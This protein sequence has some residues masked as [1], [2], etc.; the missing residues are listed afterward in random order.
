MQLLQLLNK[1]GILIASH[2]KKHCFSALASDKSG[3]YL[4]CGYSNGSIL[5]VNTS[6]IH[7]KN[8]GTQLIGVNL[9][10]KNLTFTD[11]N[12]L[13]AHAKPELFVPNKHSGY[14]SLWDT[15]GN[16]IINFG[17]SVLDA[18]ISKNGRIIT[19]IES[20][21]QSRS[22]AKNLEL[23]CYDISQPLPAPT[24]KQAYNLL[25]ESKK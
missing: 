12:L 23:I 2:T 10:I 25:Q 17:S 6:D 22:T 3:N 21:I 16:F 11:N 20:D 7:K 19:I 1:K 15:Q 9:P 4:A 14:A 5:L 8:F 24:L 18:N 13:F